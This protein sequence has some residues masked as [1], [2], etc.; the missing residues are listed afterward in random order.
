MQFWLNNILNFTQRWADTCILM[1]LHFD[2]HRG[3]AKFSACPVSGVEDTQSNIT[4]NT[5][6]IYNTP[7][8]CVDYVLFKTRVGVF[9]QI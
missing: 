5:K 9:Y 7:L 3:Q 2:S 4:S 8:N 1:N 6:V